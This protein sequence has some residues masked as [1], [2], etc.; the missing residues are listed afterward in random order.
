MADFGPSGK[1]RR[2]TVCG[3]TKSLT[4]FY[5]KTPKTVGNRPPRYDTRCKVCHNKQVKEYQNRPENIARVLEYKRR[6]YD[7]VGRFDTRDKSYN[8]FN[9]DRTAYDL[10][11]ARQNGRCAICLRLPAEGEARFAF[12]HD[13]ELGLA[14]GVLCPA[15]NGGL[16]CYRDRQDLLLAALR[17]LEHWQA[18]QDVPEGTHGL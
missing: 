8:K 17:Y 11:F 6:H 3:E 2:C 15:C 14:R 5:R 4:D 7:L 9:A 18:E 13:H 12:D 10:Q 1:Q 16:G